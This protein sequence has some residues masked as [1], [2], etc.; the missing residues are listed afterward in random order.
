[1]SYPT[2]VLP[3]TAI[4]QEG[5]RWKT[6]HENG[7]T[8]FQIYFNTPELER[9]FAYDSDSNFQKDNGRSIAGYNCQPAVDENKKRKLIMK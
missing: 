1:L 3:K 2:A 6:L 4:G 9:Y 8:T 7:L 5:Q